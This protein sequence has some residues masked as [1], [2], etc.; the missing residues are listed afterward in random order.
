[1]ILM[2]WGSDEQKKYYIPR[3]LSAEDI[4]CQGYIEPV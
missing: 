3:I 1:M 2:Y 4:W